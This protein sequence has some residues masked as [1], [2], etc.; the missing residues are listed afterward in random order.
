MRAA[1]KFHRASLK[2]L[3]KMVA[4]SLATLGQRRLTATVARFRPH[5]DAI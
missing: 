4:E 1:A 2:R 5:A 3:S